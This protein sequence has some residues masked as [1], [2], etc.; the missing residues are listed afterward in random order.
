M[1]EEAA[2]LVIEDDQKRPLP[3]WA[4]GEC[5]V[6]GEHELLAVPDVRWRVVVVCLE[7]DRVE[8]AEVGINPGDGRQRPKRGVL[9]KARRFDVD[10]DL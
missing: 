6:D 1:V 2:V 4:G 7:S 5:V 8:V 10:P 3:L 9:Q